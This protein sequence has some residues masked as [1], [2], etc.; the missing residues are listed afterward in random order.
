[1]GLP[2]RFRSVRVAA[3]CSLVLG[4]LLVT[5]FVLAGQL[6][7]ET[8]A[9]GGGPE[10]RMFM[11]EPA[12]ACVDNHCT[13][14]PGEPFTL[15]VE[16]VGAPPEGYLLVQ[17][18]I[19][20]GF[21]LVYN[22]TA[23]IPDEIFWPD[24]AETVALRSIFRSYDGVQWPGLLHGCVTGILPPLTFSDYT[25]TFLQLS[26]ACSEGPSISEVRLLRGGTEDT[27]D[28]PV[29]TDGASFV[30]DI[31]L[32]DPESFVV[33]KVND[34]TIECAVPS[35]PTPGGPTLTPTPTVTPTL[36]PTVTATPCDGPCPTAPPTPGGGVS[37][38][39]STVTPTPTATPTPTM[40]GPSQRPCGDVNGD[41]FVNAL[42][43]LWILW[44]ELRMVP[45]L[46][47]PGD[48][49]GDTLADPLDALLILQIEANLF[50]CLGPF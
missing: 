19:E 21:D 20:V 3:V 45:I 15:E 17:T 24:C 18:A 16:I 34:L 36:T 32:N 2:T 27:W 33:P 44:F 11:L 6:S 7:E 40:G 50:V 29:T 1:M 48:L 13:L 26:F 37:T 30:N 10:L 31:D 4:I 43:A 8:E 35:T 5:A 12:D 49:N 39:T 47:F 28:E 38:P 23:A 14:L 41:G 25:G 46:P 42:D 9:A 22:P